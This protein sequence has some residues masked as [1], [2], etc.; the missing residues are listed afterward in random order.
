MTAA[1][2]SMHLGHRVRLLAWMQGRLRLGKRIGE[3]CRLLESLLQSATL[4]QGR[5]EAEYAG[6]HRSRVEQHTKFDVLLLSCLGE[7]RG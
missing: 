2:E 7:I 5:K 1:D 3:E 4:D 6:S